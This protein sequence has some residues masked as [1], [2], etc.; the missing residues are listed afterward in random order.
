MLPAI[1]AGAA[2]V[3][4]KLHNLSYWITHT[5]PQP[6]MSLLFGKLTQDF[7]NF[8]IIIGSLGSTDPAI[9]AQAAQNLPDA[10]S[11]FRSG[12][13][14]DALYLTLIGALI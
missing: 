1:G 6:L 2:Q 5:S 13:A 8:Q 9:A 12:A 7:V 10:A 4:L 14:Q 3:H 11:S